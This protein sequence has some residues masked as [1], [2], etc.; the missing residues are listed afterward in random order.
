[1]LTT[2]S[3]GKPVGKAWEGGSAVAGCQEAV[4]PM[5]A[6]L[7]GMSSMIISSSSSK[8]TYI[9]CHA[10]SGTHQAQSHDQ[11]ITKRHVQQAKQRKNVAKR[12]KSEVVTVKIMT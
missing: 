3:V 1:M 5:E 2:R 8:K 4:S 9:L 11:K 7:W 10:P 12:T 6:G